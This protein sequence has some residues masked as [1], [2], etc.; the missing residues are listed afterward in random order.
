MQRDKLFTIAGA[1]LAG[2]SLILAVVSI[3]RAGNIQESLDFDTAVHVAVAG[4]EDH[5]AINSETEEE[6]EENLEGTPEED[7]TS[8]SEAGQGRINIV[9]HDGTLRLLN[10]WLRVPKT[11]GEGTSEDLFVYLDGENTVKYNSKTNYL[12]VNEQIIIKTIDS[13]DVTYN[14]I[15][16]FLGTDGTPILI[17]ERQ[18][19]EISAIAAV[20]NLEGNAPATE[21]DIKYV[22]QILNAAKSEVAVTQLTIFGVEV[23]PEWAED[24][25]MTS[26]AVQLIKGESSVYASPYTSTFAGGTTNTLNAGKVSFSYSDNIKDTSTG[27]APYIYEFKADQGG[28]VKASSSSTNTLRAKFLAQSNMIMK[29]IFE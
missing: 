28:L 2:V 1:V 5:A 16:E 22:Q 4:Q 27:Y 15:S 29:D 3:V 12:V 7:D 6:T 10:S 21:E 26:K 14:G 18:V 17:G 20:Y 9:Q 24:M 8:N 23:N 19:N 25:V 11:G 13:A